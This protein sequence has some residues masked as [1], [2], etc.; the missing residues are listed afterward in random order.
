LES[1]YQARLQEEARKRAETSV[2]SSGTIELQP[3]S[4]SSDPFVTTSAMNHLVCS[5]VTSMLS[6]AGPRP[7][8][9]NVTLSGNNIITSDHRYEGPQGGNVASSSV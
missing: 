7:F 8:G 3:V 5:I 6:N 9:S 4:N 2:D 1:E